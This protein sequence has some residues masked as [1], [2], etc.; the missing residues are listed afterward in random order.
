MSMQFQFLGRVLTRYVGEGGEV[1]IPASVTKIGAK[2]FYASTTI[3]KVVIPA[4]V[5]EVDEEAFE[6]CTA[7]REVEVGCSIINSHAFA[8]CAALVHVTFGDKV[9][10]IHRNA[11]ANDV[12]L[13]EVRLPRGLKGLHDRAFA[14][15]FGLSHLEVDPENTTFHSAGNCVIHTDKKIVLLA[16]KGCE[17]PADGSVV[18]IGKSAMR[19]Q[20]VE[21][22]LIPKTVSRLGDGMLAGCTALETLEVAEDNPTY[23]SAGNCIIER[24]SRTLAYGCKNSVIPADGSVTSIGTSAFWDIDNLTH[25]FI[26][27]S[28]RHIDP[29]KC[30]FWG[31]T[32]LVSIEVDKDNRRFHSVDNCLI[33]TEKRV[34]VLG[35]KNSIIPD[36]GSVRAI[37]DNAFAGNRAIDGVVL[38]DRVLSVGENAYSGCTALSEFVAGIRLREIG[39]CAFDS[40]TSLERVV[41]PEQMD[42]IGEYA[43]CECAIRE[44]V[45]PEGITYMVLDALDHCERLEKIVFPRTF[46]RFTGGLAQE[47]GALTTLEVAEGNKRYVVRG[48][49]LIERDVGI[50]AMGTNDSVIPADGSVE[51]IKAGA[52][53]DRN[54]LAHIDIPPT[55]KRIGMDAFAGCSSLSSIYVPDSVRDIGID[56]FSNCT[57]LTYL[58]LPKDLADANALGVNLSSLERLEI[59]PESDRY[60]SVNNCI[61][62]RDRRRMVM[63]CKTSVIPAD[64]T[65]ETIASVAYNINDGVERVVVPACVRDV[66]EEAFYYCYNLREV[67]IEGKETELMFDAFPDS[68]NVTVYAPRGSYA[69][70]YARE[71]CVPFVALQ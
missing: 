17:I 43:F 3:T 2:A 54:K 16:C 38:P 31:C 58:R 30:P 7:L 41:L 18:G 6:G 26:P 45:I 33:D 69:E 8:N 21:K 13:R 65:V 48:N 57:S 32:G 50:L 39:T 12:S 29:D 61:I 46:D 55:I 14:G 44:F 53:S 1:V 47:S 28:V 63:G 67:V 5:R 23:M 24:E 19:G 37:G 51:Y 25:L 34:L 64:G 70:K 56:A 62:E 4:T 9:E 20:G 36:D 68:P 49:C 22:L 71:Y 27:K 60:I 40:C 42:K 11:F 59:S 52:F 15:C 66:E 35:C 10:V